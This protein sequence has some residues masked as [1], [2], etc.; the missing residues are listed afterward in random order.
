MSPSLNDV[1]AVDDRPA[2]QALVAS[3]QSAL[4]ELERILDECSDHWGYEDPFYRFYHQ[5]FKVYALG[6]YH[7]PDR[8]CTSSP[9]ARSAAQ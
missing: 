9:G 5:S 3:L 2:V 8:V 4:P 6:R 7:H 1:D